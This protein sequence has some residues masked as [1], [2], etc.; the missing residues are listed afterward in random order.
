MTQ[1]FTHGYA[2]L[3][4]VGQ[5]A[6]PTLSL[7][8][9]VKDMQALRQ[10][11]IDPN[12]CAYPD[13]DQHVRLLHDQGATQQAILA[14][15]T[16]LSAQATA[17]PEA[18]VIVYYS[19]HGW[20]ETTS[21]RYYLIPHD[22]DAYDWRNTALSADDFNQALRQIPAK[23]LLVILDCCHAAGMATAKGEA[24]EPRLPK[25]VIPT[26]D[27]KGLIDALEQGE[28]RVVF[29]SCR[30]EQKSWIRSDNTLSVYTYHLI[31]ALQGAASQAGATEV[32]VFDL[33]NHLGK[34][35]PESAAAMGKQQ[36][37]RFEMAET[38]R[39]A[40]ALL[41]GGKGLPERG[42][43][44]IHPIPPDAGSRVVT[45]AGERSIA[46]GGNVSGS[47]F[48]TGD[49]NVVGSG[50]VVQ[51][52]KY[53][54]NAHSMS[55]LQIGDTYGS[56]EQRGGEEKPSSRKEPTLHTQEPTSEQ[57]QESS[58][59]SVNSKEVFISY[60]W[61]NKSEETANQIE[62]TL[63]KQGI[64]LIRDK[65]HLGFKGRIKAFMERIGRGKCVVLIISE[66]YL[67]SENCMFELLQIAK[68]EQFYERIFPIVLD[69]A[70]IYKPK[71]RIQYVQYWEHE[72]Q[73]LDQQ[74]RSVSS[75]NLEGFR[76]DIDLYNE[77]RQYLPRLTNILKDM[78]TLTAQIHSES[79][80]AELI[81]AIAQK[82]EE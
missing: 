23:R 3:I 5:C 71:D 70:R 47:T 68:N 19:G 11:L 50:N 36:T 37:P 26:A 46:I 41:Q 34:A 40:I 74:I 52:G 31:E 24:T 51:R 73:E 12:L 1:T 56:P 42:W 75:A 72:I 38:E 25:G 8:V 15:L 58:S 53:N 27:P 18:T 4:G 81:K 76:E 79:G 28:G 57:N 64:L 22:F 61:G 44:A 66:K 16:W 48:V 20:L 2:L 39:F 7:P 45:A 69:D 63:E 67:K 65:N 30:G 17:D 78:N 33:A 62:Q 80:F 6:N 59:G 32:T 10:I 9:T 49:G 54:F 14:G 43:D 82:L 21:D 35:A 77:I 13:N 60:A 55:G 29:T